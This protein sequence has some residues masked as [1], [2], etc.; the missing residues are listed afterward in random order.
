MK[1][2]PDWKDA[3]RWFS[4]QAFLILAAVPPV[5]ASLPPDVKA[6]LP[7]TWQPWVLCAL[8]VAGVIGRLKDQP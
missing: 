4:V 2:V 1:L 5:W 8:A 6:M 3:W 7:D